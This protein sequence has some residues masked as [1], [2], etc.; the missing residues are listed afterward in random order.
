MLR[1]LRQL[2][3]VIEQLAAGH[4]RRNEQRFRQMI[5]SRLAATALPLV[6]QT[7]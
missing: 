1:N 2:L 5:Y 4:Q 6:A 7:R 3:I